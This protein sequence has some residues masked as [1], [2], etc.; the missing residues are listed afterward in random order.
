MYVVVCTLQLLHELQCCG[1]AKSFGCGERQQQLG[2]TN[3]VNEI[4]KRLFLKFF[5]IIFAPTKGQV[6]CGMW[7]AARVDY[8]MQSVPAKKKKQH[9]ACNNRL[10]VTSAIKPNRWRHMRPELSPASVS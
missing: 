5:F 4:L 7:H 1:V 2:A 6:T 9:G 10:T 8:T 3:V